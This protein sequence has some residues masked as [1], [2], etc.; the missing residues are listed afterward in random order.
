M[1]NNLWL[2]SSEKIV[3]RQKEQ[4]IIQNE[5][6]S[7]KSDLT[8][9]YSESGVGKSSLT[10]RIRRVS[11]NMLPI[12]VVTRPEN[13]GD[14]PV[15]GT[16][17]A[18]IFNAVVQTMQKKKSSY[19]KCT[20][21]Y[22]LVHNKDAS[23]KRKS[24]EKMFDGIQ[25]KEIF[26]S[27][28]WL[29]T[30]YLF[31][32]VFQLYEFNSY[33]I[34]QLRDR[35]S[36]LI[37]SDYIRYV[38]NSTPIL[39]SIDNV[40]NMDSYSLQLMT[41]WLLLKKGGSYLILEYTVANTDDLSSLMDFV[42][43]LQNYSLRIKLLRLPYLKTEDALKAI[44]FVQSEL[45]DKSAFLPAAKKFYETQSGGSMR[46]L[47]DFCLQ[48]SEEAILSE[49]YDPTYDRISSASAE[50]QYILGI[51]ILHG[52]EIDL[53]NLQGIVEQSIDPII[54]N[55][56]SV[57]NKAETDY[58]LLEQ[59]DNFLR[60]THAQLGD[61]WNAHINLQRKIDLLVQRN[62]SIYYEQVL[63][64]Q[65]S[66][67]D[68]KEE[69]VL[70]LMKL[71]ATY[72]PDK[73]ETLIA[74]MQTVMVD[75]VQPERA[76]EYISVFLQYIQGN[77]EHFCTSICQL[78]RFCFDHN[79][80]RHCLYV[81]ERLSKTSRGTK[82]DFYRIYQINCLEYLEEHQRAIDLCRQYLE[83]SNNDKS[84]YYYI[85]LLIGCY[86]S[87]NKIDDIHKCV[88]QIKCIPN[89]NEYIEYG[90][91]LRLSETYMEREEAL[92]HVLQSVIFFR[93][94]EMEM[95]EIKSGITYSFLLAVTGD[96]KEAYRELL[97]F[98]EMAVPSHL[99][100]NVFE[101]NKASILL[102]QSM[103]GA[104]VESLLKKSE[105]STNSPFDRLLILTMQLINYTE[106]ASWELAHSLSSRIELLLECE[107][108]RHL[109]AMV[110][111]DLYRF[112]EKVGKV[113]SSKKY[114]KI[115]ENNAIW[116]NTVRNKLD[117]TINV[118][119]SN[120]FLNEW[121]IGFTFFWNI[122]YEN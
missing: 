38:L 96:L 95:Q 68:R 34:L 53:H 117:G 14:N 98:E 25:Y 100:Q 82:T 15:E 63:H 103:Y 108:D 94:H 5:L 4:Q 75:R 85:L 121:V 60:L 67:T 84:R 23:I 122:D 105:L 54:L 8:I 36:M 48:Y 28:G 9:I 119:N 55:L 16:F 7:P 69:A 35:D 86:R 24:L 22:Y 37:A 43:Y 50:C 104:E 83:E 44:G 106:C 45:S 80:Y 46:S 13:N 112:Y 111:Y 78:A 6:T 87:L 66:S 51:V 32:R 118:R 91:F 33:E 12:S 73:L 59:H 88:E 93:E 11:S 42:Q 1:D 47:L 61:A 31:S 40:Q 74:P 20:F 81:L 101:L 107:T 56:T 102:L 30:K 113:E 62:C 71:Y 3:D 27:F 89:Y 114:R 90:F 70:F 18:D 99:F 49:L 58:G 29:F 65:F 116:N 76:W 120:L 17:L 19:P 115:A 72:S 79:M 97:Y 10:E 57:L 39:L 109:I 2:F 92:P 64:S 41:D 52:G 77:E 110:S 21:E 26:Q